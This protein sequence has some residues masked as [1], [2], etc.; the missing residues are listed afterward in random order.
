M[1]EQADWMRDR[2]V[3]AKQDTQGLEEAT[4]DEL[5][6]AFSRIVAPGRN[7]VQGRNE[8]TVLSG[9]GMEVTVQGEDE[10]AGAGQN[11][12]VPYFQSDKEEELG[13]L[14]KEASFVRDAGHAVLDMTGDDDQAFSSSK[15]QK[16][17]YARVAAGSGEVAPP[18]RRNRMG[19]P[20]GVGIAARRSLWARAGT[21][22]R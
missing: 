5:T 6:E 1:L 16:K 9:G 13:Y 17:W 7:K 18:P 22:R 20:C 2:T 4:G 11:V 8:T 10:T 12:F 14:T 15:Q 21:T 3:K 19:M